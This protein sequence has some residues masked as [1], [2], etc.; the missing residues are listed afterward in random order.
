MFVIPISWDAAA[1]QPAQASSP[2]PAPGEIWQLQASAGAVM[3]CLVIKRIEPGEAVAR[4]AAVDGD[5]VHIATAL[6][7]DRPARHQAVGDGVV[8]GTR[9]I[10]DGARAVGH[11]RCAA[12]RG[13]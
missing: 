10:A 2:D 12:V 13:A 8:G 11:H 1:P 4:V 3:A 9:L 5:T 7:E 6:G